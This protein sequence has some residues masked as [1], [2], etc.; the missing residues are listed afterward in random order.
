M[1]SENVINAFNDAGVPVSYRNAADFQALLDQDYK[2][3]SEIVPMLE[4]DE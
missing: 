4:G 1:A 2:D 3:M